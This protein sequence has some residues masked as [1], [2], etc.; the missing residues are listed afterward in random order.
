MRAVTEQ[1]LEQKVQEK[2]HST[3]TKMQQEVTEEN[4]LKTAENIRNKASSRVFFLE[5]AKQTK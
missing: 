2:P 5:H 1:E 4:D 3:H